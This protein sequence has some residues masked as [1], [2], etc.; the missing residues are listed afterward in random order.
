M[1][2]AAA[3]TQLKPVHP[4]LEVQGKWRGGLIFSEPFAKTMLVI[5]HDVQFSARGLDRRHPLLRFE[6][7]QRLRAEA[8]NT[9]IGDGLIGHVLPAALYEG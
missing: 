2:E 9:L 4:S 1:K 5:L 8:T 3:G 7:V 6:S